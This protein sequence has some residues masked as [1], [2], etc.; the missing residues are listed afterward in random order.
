MWPEWYDWEPAFT[1]HVERRME[2]RGV[3]E[4]EVR[5]MLQCASAYSPSVVM[6][7]LY[8]SGR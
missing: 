4:V 8:E 2:E 1:G 3:T 6:V 5:S 7:T